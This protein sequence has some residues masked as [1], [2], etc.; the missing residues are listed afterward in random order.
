MYATE[1]IQVVP[2]DSMLV[3]LVG[4]GYQ[5]FPE[6]T[7]VDQDLMSAGRLVPFCTSKAS[8]IKNKMIVP[9][10]TIVEF[11]PGYGQTLRNYTHGQRVP[12]NELLAGRVI[13]KWPD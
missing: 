3:I 11:N 4:D 5:V 13:C 1:T 9:E 6:G 8:V 7:L 12:L 10:G 2:Q